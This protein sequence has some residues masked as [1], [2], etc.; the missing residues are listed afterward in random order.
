MESSKAAAG[1]TDAVR[2]R[3]EISP[4]GIFPLKITRH[5][6]RAKDAP[7]QRHQCHS[8]AAV[9]IPGGNSPLHRQSAA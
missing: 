6:T 3:A 4:D 1:A 7:A 9:C 5:V 2:S 8:A